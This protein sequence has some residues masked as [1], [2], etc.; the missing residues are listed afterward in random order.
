MPLRTLSAQE[1]THTSNLIFNVFSSVCRV[2]PKDLKDVFDFLKV[3]GIHEDLM[4]FLKV[5]LH[6][7]EKRIYKALLEDVYQFVKS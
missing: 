1:N 3:Q 5:V 2:F 7:K 6:D 4:E